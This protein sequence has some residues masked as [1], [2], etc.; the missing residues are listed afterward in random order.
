M[1]KIPFQTALI[2]F[3]LMLIWWQ[4][5]L[6]YQSQLISDERAEVADHLASHGKSLATSISSRLDK[7]DGLHAFVQ[8]EM[9]SSPG[10]MDQRF[11][12]FARSE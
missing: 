6:W 1:S 12:I 11:S 7:L 3:V 8:A 5:G 10:L 4:A 2:A 9:G